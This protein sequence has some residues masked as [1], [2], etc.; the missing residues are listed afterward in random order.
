MEISSLDL[1][2]E[3]IRKAA[4]A[5]RRL[6]EEKAALEESLAERESE[7]AELQAKLDGAPDD[8]AFR[9]LESLR[10]E[11]RDMLGRVTRML[12]LLDEE[13]LPEQKSLL[14]ARDRKEQEARHDA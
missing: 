14:A 9:E 7:V 11:R 8:E 4:A 1:L 2:E 3:R 10:R 6:R 12:A 5:I 13:A